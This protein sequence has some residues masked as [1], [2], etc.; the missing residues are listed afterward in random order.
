MAKKNSFA[1]VVVGVS[2]MVVAGKVA[3]DKYRIVKKKFDKEENDSITEEVKKYNCVADKKVI[4][5]EDEEFEGCEI[6]AIGSKMVLDLSFAVF[7]KDVY[8]NF[9]SKCSLVTIVLPEGVNVICDIE[10]VASNVSNL[11]DN[12]NEEDIHTVYIIGK[13][14]LSNIKVVPV[15]FYGEDE[16]FEDMDDVD[17]L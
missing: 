15:A 7:Q 13:A 1:K 2:A 8:I 3:Y 10:K 12:V 17:E 16:D 9:T 11:V 5:I 6:K 4:E 14:T